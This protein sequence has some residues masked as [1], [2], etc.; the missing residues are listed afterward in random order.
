MATGFSVMH[1]APTGG[2]KLPSTRPNILLILTED[3][4]AHLGYVGTAGIQT[5]HMD[6]LAASGTYFNNAF[7]VYPVCS[8]SK[9]ALYT[10]LHSHTNGLLNNTLNYHKPASA[11]TA[12]ERAAPMGQRN[13]INAACPTLVE[14][15]AAAGYYQGVTH[16]LHVLPNEKFPY[17]E[18]IEHTN[19]ATFTEFLGRAKAAA[20]PW[21][22]LYDISESHRPFPDSDQHPIRVSTAAVKLPGFLP[23]TPTVRQDWAEYLAAIEIAD[24]RTG[25]ALAALRVSDQ[26]GNTLVIFMGD[27]GPCFQHGK[28]TLHDLGLRVPLIIRLPGQTTGRRLDALV[29]E[30]DLLPTLLDYLNLPAPVLQHGASLRPLLD[31]PGTAK[32]HDRVFAE[33][34]DLGPL[35][36]PGMQERSVFDGRWKLIYRENTAGN[37]RQVQADAKEFKPWGNRT[38]AETVRVKAEWPE[39]YRILTE[40]DP[41]SLGGTTPALELYD[42]STDPDEMHNLAGQPGSAAEQGRLLATLATWARETGDPAVPALTAHVP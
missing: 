24:M 31:T 16:K 11:V 23:D 17:D 10:G 38:Y 2:G 13:R 14:I 41:Q 7:V 26:E 9:A 32:V 27:H 28:M 36:N 6:A 3:Q 25:E 42:L 12:A 15:L 21:F 1:A 39:A 34:S 18:F 29:S 19:G 5:P 33:I 4:G 37:W 20:K 40:M 35:P 8:A 30:I 22:Y